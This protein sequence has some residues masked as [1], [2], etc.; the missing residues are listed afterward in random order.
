ME[1]NEE[2][3]KKFLSSRSLPADAGTVAAFT[4]L[5]GSMVKEQLD[6]P[7]H[8]SRLGA[9]LHHK[10]GDEWPMSDRGDPGPVPTAIRL[11]D[12]LVELRTFVRADADAAIDQADAAALK[13]RA[14]IDPAAAEGTGRG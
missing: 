6:V 10:F 2:R 3:I 5:M 7:V 12:E 9:Y 13:E 11:L 1:I 14:K 4:K 8:E